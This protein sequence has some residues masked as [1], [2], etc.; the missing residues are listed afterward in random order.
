MKKRVI[1]I[2]IALFLIL[3]TCNT[4]LSL[5]TTPNTTNPLTPQEELKNAANDIQ[6]SSNSALEK[7]IKIP[8][9]F[10]S[11]AR[12]LFGLEAKDTLDVQM[13]IILLGLWLFFVF[14]LRAVLEFTP[15]FEGWKSWVGAIIITMLIAITGAIK[16]T[17]IFFLNLGNIFNILERWSPLK[18]GFSIIILVAIFYAL[19]IIMGIIKETLIVGRS[20]ADGVKAGAQLAKLKAMSEIERSI[21]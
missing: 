12:L 19:N 9:G 1:F 17:A 11:L 7:E 16:S 10:A 21:N 4:L 8:E 20:V 2:I 14:I 13:L 15:F 3:L 5:E 18:L 6:T